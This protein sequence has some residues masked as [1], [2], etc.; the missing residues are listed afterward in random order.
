MEKWLCVLSLWWCKWI[1]KEITKFLE[2]G[3]FKARPDPEL[4]KLLRDSLVNVGLPPLAC[5][6]LAAIPMPGAAGCWQPPEGRCSLTFFVALLHVAR[7]LAIV[8]LGM[9]TFCCRWFNPRRM[10]FIKRKDK[11][12]CTEYTDTASYSGA[13]GGRW[14]GRQHFPLRKAVLITGMVLGGRLG[15]Q[16]HPHPAPV[17]F[18]ALARLSFSVP[19]PVPQL[20]L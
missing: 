7:E 6:W 14:W 19:P 11:Y 20:P 12:L 8:G 2:P 1:K 18:S 4:W 5:W 13:Q 9:L 16:E 10:Q 3:N 15:S 17:S